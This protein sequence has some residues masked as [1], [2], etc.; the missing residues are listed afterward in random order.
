[1][2]NSLETTIK[3]SALEPCQPDDDEGGA[4]TALSKYNR[5]GSH[6]CNN[7]RLRQIY[8]VG[9]NGRSRHRPALSEEAKKPSR[10]PGNCNNACISGGQFGFWD[11]CSFGP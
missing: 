4:I 1:M 11:R 9:E 6:E 8:N 5:Y 2:K 3:V 7:P 10:F